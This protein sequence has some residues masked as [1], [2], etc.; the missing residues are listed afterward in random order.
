[1]DDNV[2]KSTDVNKKPAKKAPAKKAATPK[3]KA[4][5][6][7]ESNDND[8]TIIVFETGASYSSGGYRFTRDQRIQKVPYSL[9]KVLLELENF[10]LPTQAEVDDFITNQEV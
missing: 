3:Q 8:L 2:I 6:A 9:A 4:E 1:M 5:I 7:V 10:R